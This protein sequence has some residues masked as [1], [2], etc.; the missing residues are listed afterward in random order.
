MEVSA[1][2]S[3][4]G[5]LQVHERVG[6]H[7]PKV[8]CGGNKLSIFHWGLGSIAWRLN[9]FQGR[10]AGALMGAPSPGPPKKSFFQG[11]PYF[12]YIYNFFLTKLKNASRI[13]IW[14]FY[15][16]ENRVRLCIKLLWQVLCTFSAFASDICQ[17]FRQ[18]TYEKKICPAHFLWANQTRGWSVWNV[19]W[20]TGQGVETLTRLIKSFCN[21]W[22]E[23]LEKRLKHLKKSLKWFGSTSEV[24]V[25]CSHTYQVH[26]KLLK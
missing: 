4:W 12:S 17:C 24:F 26:Q 1:S 10:H 16:W 23:P 18:C 14:W 22:Q 15:K 3:D 2:N 19:F 13:T 25:S 21:I 11:P 7:F 6:N 9:Y 20:N 5:A 8:N